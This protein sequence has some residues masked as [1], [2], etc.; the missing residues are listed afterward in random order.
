M[1]PYMKLLSKNMRCI[2]P[3]LR[4]YGYSSYNK[5]VN[6]FKDYAKDLIELIEDHL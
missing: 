4:G 5:P 2:S 6:S 1:I 3:C